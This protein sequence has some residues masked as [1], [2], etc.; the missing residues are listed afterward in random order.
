M[1]LNATENCQTFLLYKAEYHRGLS[2]APKGP[3]R[4]FLKSAVQYT[5]NGIPTFNPTHTSLELLI[6]GDVERNP[7]DGVDNLETT[8]VKLPDKGLRIGEWNV[9][10]LTDSKF[11][12]ISL[13]LGTCNNIDILFLLETFLKPSKPDSVYSIPGYNLYRKDRHGSKSGG[14]LL[15]YIA[16]RVKAK[17]RCE[18]EDDFVESLW[19]DVCPHVS[20]RPILVGA[21]SS[22]L[23]KYGR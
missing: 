4:K 5:T 10:H 6:A 2:R 11:E 22:P 3:K 12:Q 16:D 8:Q 23:C 21:L 9:Q 13:I 17:R 1:Y 14:G 15:A 19:F 18:L 20:N 7:G